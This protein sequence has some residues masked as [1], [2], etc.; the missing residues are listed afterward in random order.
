MAMNPSSAAVC[1]PP[2]RVAVIG[3]GY[4]GLPLAV[5]L[6][7][8]FP[9]LGFDRQPQRIQELQRGH[10]R[11]GEVAAEV[12]AHLPLEY[13]ADPAALHSCTVFIIAVPTPVDVYKRP[14]FGPLEEAT[15]RVATILAAQA[16]TGPMPTRPL[17]IYESTVYPGATEEICIPRLEAVS[18]LRCH[19]D[20][21]VGYSP[22]RLNPG[23]PRHRLETIVKVTAGSDA[24]AAA[25]VAALYRAIIPAGVHEAPSLRVAEA[26][27]VI[28]NIQ[29]DVNIAL[30]NELAVL[31]HQL[32]L[33]SRAVFAA[34]QTKWNFLPFTPGLVGGHCIGVDPYYLTHK[35]QEIGFH[36]AMILAGRRI[37]DAMGA[38]V[39]QRV[40]ALLAQRGF[41][42]AGARVLLLG[43]TF[44]E[45]CPDLRNS[46]VIDVIR[47]LVRYGAAVA[48]HDP[49]AD[50]AEARAMYGLDL[51]AAPSPA[52][53]DR[54]DALIVAVAHDAFRQPV[55][56][57]RGCLRDQGVLFDVKGLFP[58]SEV[59]GQL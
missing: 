3:L 44:K 17:V 6:S 16:A 8:Q 53:A 47:E 23:D 18:G 26:A 20:F 7:R 48:V 36:P 28:E 24:A 25:Q 21:A 38:H 58:R 15:H 4:V 35:A 54:Y 56:H 31:F 19:Q 57:W 2:P 29:R 55:A 12:L 27:K 39:A 42:L 33:D 30:V 41:L 49:L 45:N 1:D 52:A 11:T 10:D 13:T 43:L 46:R 9:T 32:D 22:E 34:A 37:N 5:A 40:I 14:D 59:D 51:V 50:G